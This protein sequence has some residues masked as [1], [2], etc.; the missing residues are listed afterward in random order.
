MP[1]AKL[2]LDELRPIIREAYDH[3]N[4]VLLVCLGRCIANYNYP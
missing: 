4:A 1:L 3:N 2:P